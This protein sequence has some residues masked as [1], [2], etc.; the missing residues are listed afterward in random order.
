VKLTATVATG[1][2]RMSPHET[3]HSSTADTR[4]GYPAML[5]LT[6]LTSDDAPVVN[7]TAASVMAATTPAVRPSCRN[8]AHAAVTRQMPVMS[9]DTSDMPSAPPSTRTGTAI[10]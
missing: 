7:A 1:S 4:R 5:E 2:S 6:G 10:R 9:T 3:D 8:T